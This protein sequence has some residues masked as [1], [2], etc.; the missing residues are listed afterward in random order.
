MSP[1]YCGAWARHVSVALGVVSEVEAP[2]IRLSVS[3]NDLSGVIS[4]AH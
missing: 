2:L 4:D 1:R 3:E